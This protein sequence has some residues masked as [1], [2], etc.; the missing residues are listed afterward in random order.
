MTEK[1]IKVLLI[2]DNPADACLIREILE[3]EP[4]ARFQ[5]EQSTR[6]EPALERLAAGDVD[7]ALLDLALPDSQGFETFHRLHDHSPQLPIVVLTGLHDETVAAATLQSGGQD[8]LNKG[9]LTYCVLHKSIRYAIERKR[10]KEEMQGAE[11][12]AE[13]ADR[14]RDEFLA[15]LSDEL[16]TPLSSALSAVSSLLDDPRMAADLVPTLG[17]I[18]RNGEQAARL[19]E[20]LLAYSRVGTQG[21]AFRPTD[22]QAALDQALAS[23]EPAIDQAGAVVTHGCLPCLQADATQL[24]QLFQNL[25]GNAIT[26]RGDV[27]PRVHLEAELRDREWVFSVVDNGNSFDPQ[28]AER[29]FAT[30][31]RLGTGDQDPGTG[32]SLAICKRIVHRHGGR[33]WAESEPCRGSRVSFTIPA[34]VDGEPS[35]RNGAESP[36]TS[37]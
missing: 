3:E 5:V 22:C 28:H 36:S 37:G 6:L 33:I 26:C 13:A 7:V 9:A 2:E 1:S 19:F 11:E 31:P 17:M 12:A 15:L 29:M 25:I 10:A 8:Y 32:L 16:R 20:D 4:S 24:A 30:F 34:G 18:R 14:A 27:P 35:V 21:A 23:L